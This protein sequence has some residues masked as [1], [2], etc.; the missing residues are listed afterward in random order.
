[1]YYKVIGW[2]GIALTAWG[3]LGAIVIIV[4]D[5]LVNQGVLGIAIY[6]VM[7]LLSIGCITRKNI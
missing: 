4:V 5:G 1:M 2:L 6:T 3:Y 7:L